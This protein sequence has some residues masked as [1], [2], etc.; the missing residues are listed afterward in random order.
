[1]QKAIVNSEF[2][3]HR[4]LPTMSSFRFFCDTAS[5]SSIFWSFLLSCSAS[6]EKK[7]PGSCPEY[8]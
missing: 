4:D 3:E 5:K 6:A 8:H 1:M 2:A 7:I